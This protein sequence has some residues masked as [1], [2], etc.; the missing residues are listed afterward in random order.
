MVDNFKI[1][2]LTARKARLEQQ[3]AELIY[4]AVELRGRG[5]KKYIYVH[6]RLDGRQTTTYAGEYTDELHNAIE[7]NNQKARKLKRELKEVQHSLHKLGYTEKALPKK[8]QRNLDFAKRNLTLTIHSQAILEGVATTFASTEEIIEGAR[9]SNMNPQDIAKIL[10][11]KHAWEFILDEDVIMSKQDL[12]LLM[13]INKLVE[14]GFY[15]GAGNLRD[16]PVRIGGTAW[17]PEMPIESKVTEEINGIL[18]RNIT[19]EDKAIE[20]ILYVQKSQI[21]LDGNKRTAI[22]FG[23]HFLISKGLGL[24]YI[25]EEY[26]DEYKKLLVNF[27]ETGH[28]NDISKFLKEKCLLKI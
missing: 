7:K 28:K 9:V 11:M 27:Y 1:S 23:N 3:L 25:P 24:I 20:L 6:Y 17:T 2:E 8:V 22:I 15:Y 12:G 21:F 13:Q 5:N 19:N 14:E 18:S 4:G 26:I 10:N 16:V